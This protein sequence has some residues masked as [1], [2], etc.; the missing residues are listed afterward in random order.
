MRR[1]AESRPAAANAAV[2][3]EVLLTQFGHGDLTR[4]LGPRQS[5]KS[6][7]AGDGAKVCN[8]GLTSTTV[9]AVSPLR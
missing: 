6:M 4:P 1:M 2:S 8:D 3:Q 9:E 7:D 5:L